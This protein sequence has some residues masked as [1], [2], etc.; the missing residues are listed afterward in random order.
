MVL[1]HAHNYDLKQGLDVFNRLSVY[2]NIIG[3]AFHP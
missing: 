2:Y 1:F 3:I